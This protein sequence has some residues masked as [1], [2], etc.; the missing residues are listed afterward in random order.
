M[1]REPVAG[2]GGTGANLLR[3]AVWDEWIMSVHPRLF[4]G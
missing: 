3:V 1:L 4:D 2:T